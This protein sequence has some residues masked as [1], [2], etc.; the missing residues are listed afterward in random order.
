MFF[1]GFNML[2][3]KIKIKNK[4]INIILIYFTLDFITKHELNLKQSYT[5]GLID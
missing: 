4:K 1:N 5:E 2:I 3:S